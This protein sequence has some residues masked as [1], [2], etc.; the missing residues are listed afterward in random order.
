MRTAGV[1][2]LDP[3]ADGAGRVLDALE[4]VAVNALLLQRPD[5][6]LDHAVLLG[7]M[8]G[9]E[10]L[11]Q[12]VASHQGRVVAAGEDQAIVGAQQEL[13][14]DA[15]KGSEAADQGVFQG[16]C[17]RRGLAGPRNRRALLPPHQERTRREHG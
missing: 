2:E 17:G 15:A 5:H 13:V 1:I 16:A 8:R 12:A 6:T 4:A 11:S 14:A 3:V 9:D 7:A 10:L